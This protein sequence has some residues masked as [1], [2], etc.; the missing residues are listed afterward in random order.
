LH[1]AAPSIQWSLEAAQ[2]GRRAVA[3]LRVSEYKRHALE[4]RDMAAKA[5]TQ[6]MAEAWDMLAREQAKRL[7]LD[8]VDARALY[9]SKYW[10]DR[11]E[12]ARAQLEQMRDP[13]RDRRHAARGGKLREAGEDC[14]RRKAP[15]L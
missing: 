12:E 2:N 8:Q 6:D 5:E 4:C 11:A 1:P 7:G 9:P 10:R 13:W 15:R 14:S 3:L